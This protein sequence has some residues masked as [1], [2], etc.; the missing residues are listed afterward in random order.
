[1]SPQQIG[2]QLK[3]LML[4]I[5]GVENVTFVKPGFLNLNLSNKFHSILSSTQGLL[6]TLFFYNLDGPL[7]SPQV[8]ISQNAKNDP[9]QVWDGKGPSQNS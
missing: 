4:Q 3:I 7:L 9:G 2:E 6:N 5:D 1:M 8:A